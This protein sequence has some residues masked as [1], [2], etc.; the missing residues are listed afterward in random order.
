MTVPSTPGSVRRV[1]VRLLP[2]RPRWRSRQPEAIDVPDLPLEADPV[3]LVVS[4]LLT[5]VLVPAV[6]LLLL[7]LVLLSAEVAVLLALLPLLL[8][9][10]VVG[11]RPWV[12]SVTGVDGVTHHLDVGGTRQMLRDRRYYR[13]PRRS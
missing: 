2:W 13:S 1:R 4:L 3:S 5:L 11:L 12:L 8:L 6:A 10:R 9:G 7:G